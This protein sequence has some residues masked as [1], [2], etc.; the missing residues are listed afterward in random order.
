MNE[1]ILDMIDD[2]EAN[3]GYLDDLDRYEGLIEEE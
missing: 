3:E 2:M 1:D